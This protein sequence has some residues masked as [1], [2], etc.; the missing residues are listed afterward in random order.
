MVSSAISWKKR[1]KGM[2]VECK[3]TESFLLLL[4]LQ[5][6]TFSHLVVLQNTSP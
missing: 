2:E 3:P 4:L 1:N 6:T 5:S